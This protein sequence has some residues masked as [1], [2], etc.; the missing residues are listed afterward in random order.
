[1]ELGELDERERD[2]VKRRDEARREAENVGSPS[3]GGGR[4]T[5]NLE[6]VQEDLGRGEE[7]RVESRLDLNPRALDSERMDLR[8]SSRH[9]YDEIFPPIFCVLIHHRVWVLQIAWDGL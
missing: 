9:P 1:M 4:G 7:E 8:D 3:H 6:R 5:D 2:Q